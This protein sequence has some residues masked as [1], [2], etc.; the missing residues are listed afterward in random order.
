MKV[1]G[2]PNVHGIQRV[3]HIVPV[4]RTSIAARTNVGSQKGPKSSQETKRRDK[5]RGRARF[6]KLDERR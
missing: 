3:E 1:S 6:A 5:A 2:R 4:P